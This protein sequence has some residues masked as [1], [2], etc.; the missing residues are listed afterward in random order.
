MLLLHFQPVTVI[1]QLY[2][3]QH[4]CIRKRENAKSDREEV[5]AYWQTLLCL[6][7]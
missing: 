7:V 2:T 5:I 3:A 4:L 1:Q 6:D